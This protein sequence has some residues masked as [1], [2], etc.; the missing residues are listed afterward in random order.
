VLVAISFA[1]LVFD[2]CARRHYRVKVTETVPSAAH[3]PGAAKPGTAA[4]RTGA[5]ASRSS[6]SLTPPA[7][8]PPQGSVG[9]SGGEWPRPQGMQGSSG[10][11]VQPQA[12]IAAGERPSES[13]SS[14]ALAEQSRAP[15]DGLPAS[16]PRSLSPVLVMSIAAAILVAVF[17]LRWI[18]RDGTLLGH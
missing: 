2:G 11:G 14:S 10:A 17:A 4:A 9:T 8:L 5:P 13:V 12:S 16:W 6:N 7:A 3:R 15:D 18:R 1:V